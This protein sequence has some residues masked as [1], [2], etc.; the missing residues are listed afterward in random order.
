MLT[1]TLNKIMKTIQVVFFL[2]TSFFVFRFFVTTPFD[3]I[4]LLFA[5]DFVT[6]SIATDNVRYSKSPE[7]WKVKPLVMSSAVLSTMLVLEGFAGVFLSMRLGF[8][9][10]EIQTF[11]FDLLVFSGL[12][13][14]L[15]VRER[16][17]FWHSAPS[18][19]LLLSILGDIV[20]ISVISI[21]GV[22]VSPIPPLSVVYVI[23]LTFGWMVLMD[24]VKNLV[25]RRYGL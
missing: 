6:M 8:S 22:L 24:F 7:K 16:K 25:F 10:G 3:I 2:T 4:L 20:V 12:F 18:R 1:Y 9:Q 23:L 19:W 14:V 21:L 5:N 17:R 15:M 11:V 13:T